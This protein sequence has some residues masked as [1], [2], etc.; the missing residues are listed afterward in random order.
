VVLAGGGQHGRAYTDLELIGGAQTFGGDMI[1]VSQ[2]EYWRLVTG[3]FLHITN[4]LH[5]LFNMYILYWLG[6]M[7]EP[8]LGHVRFLALYFT[9]LL[10]GAFGALLL[11]PADQATVGASGAVFGLMGAA[12]V[13]QRAQGINPMQSGLGPVIILNL[14]LSVLVPG[15]SIGGHL[16]G[17]VGGV[18][19]ALA[20]QYLP[21]LR[22]SQAL[23]VAG[24]ALIAAVAVV[25]A[26]AVANAKTD[27]LFAAALGLLS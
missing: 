20:L 16:G 10:A 19:V 7:L 21:A 18:L 5:L 27:D 6:Q 25:G 22:R 11:A 3:G 2:G 8:S 24:C 12:F 1:G 9:S 17:L 13:L 26:I 23:A 14:F 4:P 15:V